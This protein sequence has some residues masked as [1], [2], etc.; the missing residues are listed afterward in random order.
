MFKVVKSRKFDYLYCII[1]IKNDYN[2]INTLTIETAVDL[3]NQST[4]QNGAEGEG[5][6]GCIC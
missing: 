4:M 2:Y 5:E 3:Q 1:I 6:G